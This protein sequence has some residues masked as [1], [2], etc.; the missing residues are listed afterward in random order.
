MSISDG[1]NHEDRDGNTHEGVEQERDDGGQGNVQHIVIG[2]T[3][4]G[5]HENDGQSVEMSTMV[6]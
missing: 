4:E 3:Y 1:A 6:M 2:I 5:G